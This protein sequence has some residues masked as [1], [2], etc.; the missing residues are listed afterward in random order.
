MTSNDFMS[1]VEWLETFGDNLKVMLDE[2]GMT[3]RELADE[4]RLSEA[5]VSSYVNGQKM[6]TARA[7]VNIAYVLDCDTD[8][9][10]NFDKLVI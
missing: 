2:Y 3:Q 4:A 6:P 9:L 8:E 10:I 5:A 1:E 7:I